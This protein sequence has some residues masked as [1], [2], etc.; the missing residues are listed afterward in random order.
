MIGALL[1]GISAF[2]VFII[3]SLAAWKWRH[4]EFP[5]S[6]LFLIAIALGS[7]MI[8]VFYIGLA[9]QYRIGESVLPYVPFSRVVFVFIVFGSFGIVGAALL[10]KINGQ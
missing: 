1:I 10:R 4:R 3:G 2:V 8:S 9:N 6:Y 7:L 5:L